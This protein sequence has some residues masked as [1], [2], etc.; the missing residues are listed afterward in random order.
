[1]FCR[2]LVLHCNQSE[3][4][5]LLPDEKEKTPKHPSLNFVL[6]LHPDSEQL[7]ENGFFTSK[8]SSW[9]NDSA[10]WSLHRK[11]TQVI[12]RLLFCVL[13][14]IQHNKAVNSNQSNSHQS[15]ACAEVQSVCE[16]IQ[17]VPWKW[18]ACVQ[19]RKK[20]VANTLLCFHSCV[21]LHC[22][23]NCPSSI[24]HPRG[25]QADLLETCGAISKLDF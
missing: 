19:L 14:E 18:W 10:L 8:S 22:P 3:L 5:F 13:L 9:R 11:G 2:L 1:M 23:A 7:A 15:F 25:T 4:T 21:T 20:E 17:T 16:T 12:Y 24:S 6:V